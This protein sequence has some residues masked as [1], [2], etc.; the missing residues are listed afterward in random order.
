MG[1]SCSYPES[2]TAVAESAFHSGPVHASVEGYALAKEI[3]AIGSR[4]YAQQYHL[5]YLH[6]VLATMYG[7][8]G[9]KE[10]DRSHF[11][12]GMLQR[13][14]YEQA[15]GKSVFSVWGNPNTVRE[16]LYVEDQI[17]AILTADQCFDNT[18]LNCAASQPVTIGQVAQ[19]ILNVLGWRVEPVY[20]EGSFQGAS[21]KVLDSSRFLNTTGW[22][23]RF[24]LHDGLQMVLERDYLR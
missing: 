22:K 19:A 24:A 17:D 9:H 21:Y 11:V 16:A 1:S 10:P 23:P 14:I 3:L 18:V 15:E 4:L 8:H 13:A 6:C 2:D 20:L 12:G 7:P 5:H